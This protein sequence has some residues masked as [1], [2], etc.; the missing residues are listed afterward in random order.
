MR[1]FFDELRAAYQGEEAFPPECNKA[2][3]MQFMGG[4]NWA[5]YHSCP[6]WYMK[7][8]IFPMRQAQAEVQQQG[9]TGAGGRMPMPRA[10]TTE[11]VIRIIEAKRAKARE[12]DEMMAVEE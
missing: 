12:F 6:T 3:I 5:D 11:D 8:V 7:E 10:K 4:W 1:R 9:A 2:L